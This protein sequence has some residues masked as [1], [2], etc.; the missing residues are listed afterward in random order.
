MELIEQ[1]D[2]IASWGNHL[3]EST[4]AELIPYDLTSPL[5]VLTTLAEF[6]PHTISHS[7]LPSSTTLICLVD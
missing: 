5:P 3:D 2:G 6:L 4:E 7:P 1:R